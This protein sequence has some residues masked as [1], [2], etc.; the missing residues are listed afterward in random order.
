MKTLEKAEAFVIYTFLNLLYDY[1]GGEG[2]IL[3]AINGVPI[4]GFFSEIS[5]FL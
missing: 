3:N 2:A 4:K 5:W 1:L